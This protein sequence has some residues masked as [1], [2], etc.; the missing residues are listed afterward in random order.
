VFG[1]EISPL[2]ESTKV[3]MISDVVSDVKIRRADRATGVNALL[4]R[5]AS[6]LARL[7]RQQVQKSG[8]PPHFV[9]ILYRKRKKGIASGA[10]EV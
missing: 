7:L 1:I 5:C 2:K 6:L 3:G 9:T 10:L 4:S 8:S